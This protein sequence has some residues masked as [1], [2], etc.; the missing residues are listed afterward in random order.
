[1]SP[2]EIFA[3]AWLYVVGA[4]LLCMF[5]DELVPDISRTWK[6]LALVLV[7]PLGF[8]ALIALY[9]VVGLRK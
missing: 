3:F 9:V 6:I 5:I 7:W 4:G 1:M 2:L 8:P